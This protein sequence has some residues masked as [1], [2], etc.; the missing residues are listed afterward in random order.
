MKV[1]KVEWGF[2]EIECERCNE[3]V[4][5]LFNYDSKRHKY[6]VNFDWR[7]KKEFTEKQGETI[8]E[9]LDWLETLTVEESFDPQGHLEGA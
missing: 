5:I 6:I 8:M 2:Y 9:F 4:N 1:R 3:M 7:E